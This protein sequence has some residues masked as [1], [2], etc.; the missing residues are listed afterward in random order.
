VLIVYKTEIILSCVKFG[1]FC[2][3]IPNSK[4]LLES[5]RQKGKIVI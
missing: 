2:E 1:Y 5:E 3:T 4:L